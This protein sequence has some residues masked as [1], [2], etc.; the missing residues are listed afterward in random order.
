MSNEAPIAALNNKRL[1]SLRTVLP[2]LFTIQIIAAVGV[3]GF[4]SYRNGQKTVYDIASQL[5]AEV[6]SRVEQHLTSYLGTAQSI[7][8]TNLHLVQQGL[9]DANNVKQLSHYFWDQGRMFKGLGTI[10]FANQ[11]GDF[12]GANE[13]EDYIVLAHRTL[14]GGAIRRYA[15]DKQGYISGNILRERPNYDARKRDWY[16]AAEKAGRPIWASI[17]P[18]VTGARLDLS[19]VTPYLDSNN[20]FRGNFM[21]DVSLTEISE[22]LNRLKIGKTGQVVIIE[23]DGNI[24][25]SSFKEVP[26]VVTDE[27]KGEVKRLSL[28]E[29]KSP[30]IVEAGRQLINKFG[31]LQSISGPRRLVENVN[32]KRYFLQ[33]A[34]Y[35][36]NGINFL[37]AVIIPEADFMEHISANNKTTAMLSFVALLISI[38]FGVW[39]SR[40]VVSPIIKLSSAAKNIGKGR[41]DQ[42]PVIDRADE[43]GELASSFSNMANQLQRAFEKLEDEKEK[44]NSIIA[45][46]GDG[47]SILDTDFKVL[48]QNQIHKDMVGSHVGEYCYAGY[49]GKTEVCN[50]C[51]IAIT[52]LDGR[53]HTTE[54]SAQYSHGTRYY[55]V[56]TSPLR[57]ATGNIIAGIE[58]VRNVTD[59][60]LSQQVLEAERERLAVTLRSIGDA[61]IVTDINGIITLVNKVAEQTTGWNAQD[62]VGRPLPDIFNIIHEATR[63]RYQN[64]VA[65]VVESGLVEDLANHT[66]LIRKNG[67]EIFIEDSAAPIQDSRGL[68]IGVVLVFRDVTEKKN[69]EVE[70]VRAQKLESVGLLAGGIAHDFNNLL[71][72]IVGNISLAKMHIE[73]NSSAYE[74]LEDAEKASL[75]ASNLTRQ[76][77]TFSRGGS[78]VKKTVSIAEILK[79][80]VNFTLS[81]S[82]VK[83]VFLI[84]ETI[85]H[86]DVDEGQMSQVFNNFVVNAIQAMPGSG[87]ITLRAANVTVAEGEIPMLQ[88]G[89]YVKIS[90]TDTGTGISAE[91][92]P[93]IFDPYFT[94]KQEGSGLGLST[95]YSIIR[96]HEG[97]VTVESKPGIGSTFAVFLKASPIQAKPSTSTEEMAI[98]GRGKILIMDDEKMVR[99]IADKMLR[100]LGYNVS[101]AQDG[102]EAID[103]YKKV[104]NTPDAF[105]VVILDLTIPGGMGGKETMQNLRRIDPAAVVLVSSGYLNDPIMADFKTYG[106]KGAIAK[107]YAIA[108]LSKVL[109]G[110]LV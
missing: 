108:E 51:P 30:L 13:P 10:A 63:E 50:G 49:E 25:A 28:Q 54:R 9:I 14:T 38:G 80:S 57:D 100:I 105:D 89:N 86:V 92:L 79:E 60:K 62:A 2:L 88:A 6:M 39:T 98:S 1:F 69:M 78:P 67:S 76:L 32:G 109:R 18:S 75:R 43:L 104:M 65:K 24:V 72:A 103:Q 90:I 11:Q 8:N 26:Y 7:N 81:G 68:I 46:I 16:Q 45:G 85:W 82:P 58:V 110:V 102:A 4:I 19:A 64:P 12:I 3:T 55:E 5:C 37:T 27:S 59:R 106:F 34:P 99:D 21:T 42:L 56:T 35:Q 40:W 48:Y 61:V 70:L 47:I 94:T 52:F 91:D 96:K 101:F 71:T 95:V 93:K 74:S 97:Q 41:W 53:I 36:N 29:S 17:S 23:R 73:S 84:D 83:A 33:I 87:I 22:F 31:D 44:T 66:V 15:P 20:I 107:P 77:L